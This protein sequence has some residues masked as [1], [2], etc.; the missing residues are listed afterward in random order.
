LDF[1]SLWQELLCHLERPSLGGGHG[2]PEVPHCILWYSEAMM[3]YDEDDMDGFFAIP[4][5]SRSST[6]LAQLDNDGSLVVY[7]VWS[8]PQRV[9]VVDDDDEGEVFPLATRAFLSVRHF[10]LGHVRVEYDFLY[11]PFSVTYK[12]CIYATGHLG[13]FRVARCLY[14]LSLD[15]YYSLKNIIRHINLVIDT[16]MDMILENDYLF[17]H[18]H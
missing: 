7:K 17:V 18:V 12:P 5:T 13:C 4:N 8:L 6:Y 15:I 1:G 9:V 14:Q 3:N 10:L 11:S 2:H 16:W